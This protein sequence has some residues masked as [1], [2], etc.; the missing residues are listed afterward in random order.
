MTS[1]PPDRELIENI[2]LAAIV[3]ILLIG[4]VLPA[5]AIGCLGL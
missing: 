5:L 2:A 4:F 3:L 1:R